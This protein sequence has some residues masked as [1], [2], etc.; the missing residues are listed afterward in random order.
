MADLTPVKLSDLFVARPF[1]AA[2]AGGDKILPTNGRLL[3]EFN[4]T[5]ASARTVTITAQVT[6]LKVKGHGTVTIGNLV[7]ALAQNEH[8]IV[9]V[10]D[11]AYR[12]PADLNKVAVTYSSDVGVTLRAIDI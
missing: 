12:N 2:S 11:A 4:N 9:E 6:T 10:P 1:L 3:L 7:L 5:N 8:A